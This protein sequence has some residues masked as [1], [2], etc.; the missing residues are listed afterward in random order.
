MVRQAVLIILCTAYLAC[1]NNESSLP[2]A[3]DINAEARE[4][5][6]EFVAA[7]L[8]QDKIKFVVK[9]SV[10]TS[11]V[12]AQTMDDAADDPAF[13][14]N[15]ENPEQ[16]VIYGT[17]K[18]GG[19]CAYNLS[20]KELKYYPLGKVNN[21]D[22]IQNIKS[23]DQSVDL[24]TCT[25][26]SSQTTMLFLIEEGVLIPLKNNEIKSDSL[27]LDDIYGVCFGESQN[28]SLPYLF[29]NAKNGKLQ[30]FS[31]AVKDSSFLVNELRTVQFKSQT[32]GMVADNEDQVL[33]VGV[34]DGGIYKLNMNLEVP[35]TLELLKAS[36][37][38]SNPSI[39]FDL[40]G[41]TLLKKGNKKLLIASSQGNFSYAVFDLNQEEKYLGSFK[42]ASAN[43]I[44][45]VEET[46]GIDILMKPLG[47]QFP[48]G[49]FVAQDG[50]NYDNDSLVPQNFKIIDNRE[51]LSL[52][53]IK[54]L[55]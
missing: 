20:G 8:S 23:S 31:I 9:P 17:N 51:I 24:L 30:Q 12:S 46:D 49:I 36:T 55:Q 38:E 42:I 4:D 48:E 54:D 34:E 7:K 53:F 45:G 39:R 14:Y 11:S 41:I 25:N 52:P 35:D 2:L 21:V 1:K 44:D 16:S 47:D 6:L 29:V 13:W 33:Y 50:F 37:M 18:K 40:E 26:R 22:V 5:S 3:K 27:V 15:S 32:E 43:H 28:A 19:L 10:E